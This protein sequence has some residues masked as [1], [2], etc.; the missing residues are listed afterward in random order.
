MTTV[1]Q[2]FFFGK[3]NI[4]QSNISS[5]FLYSKEQIIN[6]TDKK[7]IYELKFKAESYH[8]ETLVLKCD[9]YNLKLLDDCNIYNKN[10]ICKIKKKI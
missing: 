8:N 10:L 5:P 3:F 1:L 9:A 7:D 2:Y 4:K 6:L